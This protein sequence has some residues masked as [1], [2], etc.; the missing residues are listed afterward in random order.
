MDDLVNGKI[1]FLFT[2]LLL[3]NDIKDRYLRHFCVSFICL[4]SVVVLDVLT[5]FVPKTPFVLY[6]WTKVIIGNQH[7]AVFHVVDSC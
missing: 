3:K 1:L 4:R 7:A 2:L 5:L 6:Y